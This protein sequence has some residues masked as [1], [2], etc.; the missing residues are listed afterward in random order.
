M[1]KQDAQVSS[2]LRAVN[3]PIIRTGWYLDGTAAADEVTEFIASNLGLPIKG[4]GPRG[5]PPRAAARPGPVLLERA[6]SRPRCCACRSGTPTSSRSTATTPRARPGCASSRTGPPR[7]TIPGQRRPR[8][9]PGLDRAVLPRL[10]AHRGDDRQPGTRHPGQPARGLRAG[11]RGR[12]LARHE[13]PA[14]GVQE[15]AAQGPGAAH[16][17]DHVDRNGAASR[18]TRR[19]EGEPTSRR[20]GLAQGVRAGDNAGGAIPYGAKLELIRASGHLPDIDKFVRYQDEQIARAVLAHFLNLGTQTG[21]WALGSTFA[22]FFTL[23]L[24]AIAEDFATPPTATS[25]R[26]W[27]TSTSAAASPPRRSSSTRSA[28][29]GGVDDELTPSARPPASRTTTTSPSSCA[30]T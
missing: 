4:A 18:S 19:R 12:Q 15:L 5:Q 22:D 6:T 8:R 23:S 17:V 16:L 9:R 7:R 26:T 24:Q 28:A 29:R 11:P 13:H 2:V 30:P 27:S 21:S 20:Q 25:S 3:S 1:R 14:A 10:L